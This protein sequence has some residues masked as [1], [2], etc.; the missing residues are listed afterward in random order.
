MYTEVF[1]DN[2]APTNQTTIL[3]QNQSAGYQWLTF[4]LANGYTHYESSTGIAYSNASLQIASLNDVLFGRNSATA[5]MTIASPCVVSFGTN[6]LVNGQA[7]SFT[8]TGALP[9]GITVNTDYFVGNNNNSTF[10]LYDTSAN[11]LV[12]GATGRINTSGT[13]SGTHTCNSARTYATLTSPEGTVL[14]LARTGVGTQSKIYVT[15]EFITNGTTQNGG[16][17]NI[18][19]VKA[20]FHREAPTGGLTSK[21]SSSPDQFSLPI[22]A[23]CDSTLRDCNFHFEAVTVGSGS[24]PTGAGIFRF[25][26]SDTTNNCMVSRFQ[27]YGAAEGTLKDNYCFGVAANQRYG[28]TTG[29]TVAANLTA[30]DCMGWND[31]GSANLALKLRYTAIGAGAVA[32]AN[33][34]GK[35]N[36]SIISLAN[37][38][39]GHACVPFTVHGI[40]ATAATN[41]P[42]FTVDASSPSTTSNFLTCSD[43]ALRV[44][45]NITF[46]A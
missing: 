43:G 35:N 9:T 22:H 2:Q 34:F 7:V 1:S 44:N 3:L 13:Q 12:G 10:N 25:Y 17:G 16:G 21:V 11:A 30:T 26:V 29:S 15:L 27:L 18:M 33:K 5:T 36:D 14:G 20:T 23:M 28:A 24:P 32:G 31:N 38:T 37:E 42:N 39:S 19:Y 8:T 40:R 45:T 6:N 46:V 4:L 41:I